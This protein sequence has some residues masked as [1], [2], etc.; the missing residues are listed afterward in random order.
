MGSIPGEAVMGVVG[1]QFV[2]GT[3]ALGF[4]LTAEVL[5]VDRRGVR[6]G[7]GLYRAASAT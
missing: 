4:L 7:A 3:A 5:G 6:S 2:A 1:P